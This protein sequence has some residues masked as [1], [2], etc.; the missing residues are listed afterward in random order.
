MIY[1]IGIQNE[2]EMQLSGINA[3]ATLEDISELTGGVAFFPRAADA[4]PAICL[5]IGL[6]LKNQYVLGYRPQNLNK[7]GKWRKVKVKVVAP[8]GSP[9]MYVRAKT[10]YFA[11][12]MAQAM[13]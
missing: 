3:R 6:D 13:K 5:Q 8:K 11:P 4:L 1:S 12:G 10:G 7:D 9:S 2:S